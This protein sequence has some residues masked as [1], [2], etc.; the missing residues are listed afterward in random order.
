MI[1]TPQEM[2]ALVHSLT[3]QAWTLSAIGVLFESG[4]ADHLAEPRSVDELALHCRSL[5]RGR[6]ERCLAVAVTAGVV[7]AEE[8]RYRLAEGAMPFQKQPLR[9]A[10][11]GD[12]RTHVMQPLAFLDSAKQ[13]SKG[14]GWRHTD[15]RVLQAQGDASSAFAPMFK[16]NIAASMGDVAARLDRP[17]ARLLDV[18]VGVGALAIAMCRAF[19]EL[20][21][22]GLDPF[23]VPLG[24]AR[25]NIERAGLADR[26]ELRQL[27][28][29]D[30][31]DEDAFDLAWLPTFFIPASVLPAATA[32]V[33]AS[34]HPGGWVLFPVGGSTGSDAQR[35]VSALLTEL[36]GGPALS[37][38]EAES[39]L[40][41]TGMSAVR[42]LPGPSWAPSMVVAQR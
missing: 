22:V 15:V 11:E 10:L 12:I 39:L 37:T 13:E 35:S 3:T 6:I 19:P 40:K 24:V 9:T 29:E 36:W 42:T 21:V 20:G 30:F 18:G 33:R 5:S 38:A 31:K 25:K 28:V 17:G 27:R 8:T 41:E 32:R 14:E 16:A 4:L 34:L 2:R 26:I 23:E 7:T 1:E